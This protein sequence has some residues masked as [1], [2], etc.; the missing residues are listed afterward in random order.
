MLLW[1]YLFLRSNVA[2]R[3]LE[4]T[5]VLHFF[6]NYGKSDAKY[7]FERQVGY[8]IL[9]PMAENHS[10]FKVFS[11]FEF[12]KERNKILPKGNSEKIFISNSL[13]ARKKWLNQF[14]GFGCLPSEILSNKPASD[15]SQV[16]IIGD[17]LLPQSLWKQVE[18]AAEIT[19]ALKNQNTR[20]QYHRK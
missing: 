5:S 15:A 3:C 10:R 4:L 17:H 14:G 12:G 18:G 19:S 20:S 13:E 6:L 16:L 9:A 7:K 11:S 1:V 2:G 8:Q